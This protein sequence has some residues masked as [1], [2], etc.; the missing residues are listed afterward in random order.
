MKCEVLDATDC[1]RITRPK[2]KVIEYP[3][4]FNE[5]KEECRNNTVTVPTQKY[6]H[7]K[8]CIL[9]EDTLSKFP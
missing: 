2:C 4:C 1:T 7:K 8:K 6:I 3:E 5:K 9:D